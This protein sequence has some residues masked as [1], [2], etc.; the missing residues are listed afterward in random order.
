M[1]LLLIRHGQIQSNVDGI[2]DTV[3]PG[4]AL[5][6]LGREQ[7]ALLPAALD[8]EDIGS[9]WVS[10]A[11]RA[12]QTAAPLARALALEP[13]ERD[14]IREIAAGTLERKGSHAAVREY[15]EVVLSWARGDLDV[16]MPGA[17]DGHEFVERFESVIDEALLRAGDDGHG[18]V[19]VVSH[20]AAIR[21][22]ASL[23]ADNLGLEEARHHWLDNTGVAVLERTAGGWTCRTWMGDPVTGVG[24]EEPAGPTG[25]PMEQR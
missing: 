17:E 22:W 1:R 25:E 21:C 8:G 19:A 24:V 6:G 16:R 20:G 5:T 23:R 4:P 12:Q 3:V 11:L 7:A 13:A 18:T 2:L 15:V 9:I 10:T 14:G